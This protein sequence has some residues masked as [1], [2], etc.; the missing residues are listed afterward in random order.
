MEVNRSTSPSPANTYCYNIRAW[1]KRDNEIL[2]AS[3]SDVSQD[4]YDPANTATAPDITDSFV[5]NQTWHEL[6]K[7][8]YF[9][10]TFGT[11]ANSANMIMSDFKL[12]FTP[13]ASCAATGIPGDYV[14]A[15]SMYEGNGDVL[16]DLNATSHNNGTISDATW[17]SGVGCPACSALLTTQSNGGQVKVPSSSSLNL[18]NHGTVAAWVYL[19]GYSDW[20]GIVHKG[21]QTN[22]YDE[23]YTLQFSQNYASFPNS[24]YTINSNVVPDGQKRPI[25][26]IQDDH[27]RRV[28][29]TSSTRLA[30]HTWYHVAAT[31]DRPG[32]MTMY[33]NGQ[34]EDTV[35]VNRDPQSTSS[36]LSLGAQFKATQWGWTSYQYPLNG[37][38][39]QVYLYKRALTAAEIQSLYAAGLNGQ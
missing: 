8:I 15:W 36:S 1:V 13:V 38:M 14:S 6:F 4:Y 10:W 31:W 39:D 25:F 34:P 29:A 2:P 7:N 22:F 23:C 26:C 20:G 3:F 33:I 5:L 30:L 17:V 35:N 28:C 19:N 12:G 21:E 18:G 9:G 27:R 16:H 32:Q 24:S 11:G 37:V